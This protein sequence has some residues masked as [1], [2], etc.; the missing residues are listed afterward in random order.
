MA[1]LL[2]IKFLAKN[3]KKT[4]S[5]CE[6][7]GDFYQT[8]REGITLILEIF[9]PKMEE[10]GIFSNSFY[11]SNVNLI[12]KSDKNIT[13]KESTAQISPSSQHRYKNPS[14]NIS[15][16]NP[17]IYKKDNARWTSGFILVMQG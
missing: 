9:P 8:L 1:Y 6:F 16:L 7:S 15:K 3:S 11:E 2:K 4:P 14:Q 17:A 10:D 5:P 13:W 12:S